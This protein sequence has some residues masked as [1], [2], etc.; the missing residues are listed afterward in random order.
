ME[1]VL[2]KTYISLSQFAHV[3]AET[4]AGKGRYVR[5]SAVE[6]KADSAGKKPF[7]TQREIVEMQVQ[8]RVE[9]TLLRIKMEAEENGERN[10]SVFGL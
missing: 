1:K 7:Y 3:V 4:V 5:S 9:R 8:Q 10:N 6:C 2:Q